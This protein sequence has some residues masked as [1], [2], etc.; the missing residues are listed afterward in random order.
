MDFNFFDAYKKVAPKSN[1]VMLGII[2][3][4]SMGFGLGA[5]FTGISAFS[6]YDYKTKIVTIEE[7]INMDKER[8]KDY[9]KT[10][11]E[12]N[13]ANMEYKN[14]AK[15]EYYT[16]VKHTGSESVFS[17]FAKELSEN[18]YINKFNIA[19]NSVN[20]EG[21]GIDNKTIADYESN[22]RNSNLF[23][24]VFVEL[25]EVDKSF[26]PVE[27]KTKK[28]PFAFKMNLDINRESFSS[29]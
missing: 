10:N 25:S 18:L 7:S 8:L 19:E 13:K 24:R 5:I 9:D 15:I 17:V 14:F 23:K 4:L 11:A 28:R 12:F 21:V 20:I 16:N 3:V 6:M 2:F 1:F 27:E 22:L 29:K 26:E